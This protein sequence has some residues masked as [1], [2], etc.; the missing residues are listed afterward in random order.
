[1]EASNRP[2][3]QV[4]RINLVDRVVSVLFQ[5][6]F[7]RHLAPFF[8]QSRQLRLVPVMDVLVFFN[9]QRGVRQFVINLAHAFLCRDP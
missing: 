3:F 1:M 7:F 4:S 2:V 5:A 6:L 8:D 9:W